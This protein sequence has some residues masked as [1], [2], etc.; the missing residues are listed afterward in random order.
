MT[1]TRWSNSPTAT[2]A[3]MFEVSN[4]MVADVVS[5]LGQALFALQM[6]SHADAQTTLT[7]DTLQEAGDVQANNVLPP[8]VAAHAA[9]ERAQ[10]MC[11]QELTAV[12]KA[13]GA[14]TVLAA[15]ALALSLSHWAAAVE[16]AM[17]PFTSAWPWDADCRALTSEVRARSVEHGASTGRPA[18]PPPVRSRPSPPPVRS[19]PP[20]PPPPVPRKRHVATQSQPSIFYSHHDVNAAAP[21]EPQ[22]APSKP[23]FFRS[24]SG[25][26]APTVTEEVAEAQNL[27]ETSSNAPKGRAAMTAFLRRGISVNSGSNLAKTM[28][29]TSKPPRLGSVNLGERLEGVRARLRGNDKEKDDPK[30]E[31][32]FVA[33]IPNV[34]QDKAAPF[35]TPESEVTSYG[36]EL[37]AAP[38]QGDTSDAEVPQARGQALRDAATGA[39]AAMG[40]WAGK[41]LQ[42]DAHQPGVSAPA[43]P[44]PP[45]QTPELDEH[46]RAELDGIVTVDIH[47]SN[48]K[49]SK[50]L[51]QSKNLRPAPDPIA[52]KPR[53]FAPWATFDDEE[54]GEEEEPAVLV[55]GCGPRGVHN[56]VHWTELERSPFDAPSPG[57]LSTAVRHTPLELASVPVSL[58]RVNEDG[59]SEFPARPLS[60]VLMSPPSPSRSR[61]S[62][63][64]PDQGAVPLWALSPHLHDRT[65]NA[66]PWGLSRQW[67]ISP[68][69][70]TTSP[71]PWTDTTDRNNDRR[72]LD[73]RAGLLAYAGLVAPTPSP[74][75]IPLH[76]PGADPAARPIPRPAPGPASGEALDPLPDTSQKPAN[77]ETLLQHLL[78]PRVG[79]GNKKMGTRLPHE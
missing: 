69:I 37:D 14:D 31:S 15:R 73:D 16:D 22:P 32:S 70:H 60:H 29:P 4:T 40:G 41:L 77:K 34:N 44:E 35:G 53:R 38:A 68:S 28:G 19:R 26:I 21:E 13:E 52:P 20:P 8:L 11:T 54:E 2:A 57:L 39:K 78:A 79:F 64:S 51:S 43:E 3:T 58:E 59:A 36:E 66:S 18:P 7:N 72:S 24:E 61:F 65:T 27:T 76:H 50:R 55:A 48:S 1:A 17:Q 9:L 67:T 46:Q 63:P 25:P 47:R 6:R 33:Q 74:D 45:E 49:G 30:D 75:P 56:S 42:R 62:A 10:A 5:T 23:T 71:A 12:T